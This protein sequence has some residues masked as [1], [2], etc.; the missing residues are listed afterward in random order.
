MTEISEMKGYHILAD[1]IGC[2]SPY[3]E[4]AEDLKRVLLEAASAGNFDVVGQCFYQFEPSGATGVLLLEQSHISAHSWPEL[5]FIAVDIY[6]CGGR[7]KAEKAKDY[8]IK[9]FKPEEL[10][11]REVYRYR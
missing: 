10:Q 3:L 9:V 8:L 2:P 1:F 11:V 5:G 6:S 7:E 4:Q